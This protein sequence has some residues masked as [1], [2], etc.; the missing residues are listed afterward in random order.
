MV[1][2]LQTSMKDSSCQGKEG[3]LTIRH[4]QRKKEERKKERKKAYLS[5]LTQV[6]RTG[7]DL[8]PWTLDLGGHVNGWRY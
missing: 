6:G 8:G 5:Y 7:W 3:L 4:W 2:M 1:K